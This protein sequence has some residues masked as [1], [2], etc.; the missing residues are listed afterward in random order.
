MPRRRFALPII[1]ADVVGH[2]LVF[3]ATRSDEEIEKIERQFNEENPY[4]TCIP[5]ALAETLGKTD[6]AKRQ[7][8]TVSMMTILAIHDQLLT[9][10]LEIVYKQKSRRKRTSKKRTV[11][12]VAKKGRLRSV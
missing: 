1:T 9:D 7:I 4:L 6:A 12:M 5:F 10:A 11:K 8:T 2:M 3:H